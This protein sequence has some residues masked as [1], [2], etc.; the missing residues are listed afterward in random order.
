M[1]RDEL[2]KCL[3]MCL[4]GILFAVAQVL[5]LLELGLGKTAIAKGLEGEIGRH[6]NCAF[7]E[8]TWVSIATL[9]LMLTKD[10]SMVLKQVRR[11]RSSK[12]KIKEK[13]NTTK[14]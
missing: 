5:D 11:T 7:I 1:P 9:C 10:G 3:C 14:K 12:K 13:H 6:I 2:E 8:W 4:H